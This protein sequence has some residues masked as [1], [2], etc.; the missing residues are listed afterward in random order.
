LRI[1]APIFYLKTVIMQTILAHSIPLKLVIQDLAKGFGVS[2]HQ[3]CNEYSLTLPSTYG[4]G[5]ITG[6]D[7]NDG[8]GLI[9]YDCTFYEAIQIKF[10]V[11]EIHPL[12]FL[13]CESGTISHQFENQTSW[14]VMEILDNMIVASDEKNGHVLRFEAG[15]KTVVNSLEVNRAEFVSNKDCIL[16]TLG[17]KS[18]ELF[19]DTTASKSFYHHSNYSVKMADL[20]IEF[21]EFQEEEFLR[22]LFLESIASEILIYQILQYNDDIALPENKTVLRKSEIKLI[23][24]AAA[25]IDNNILNFQSVQHLANQVGIN[26]NKL[27]NGFKEIYRKTVN[28]YVQDSR[29]DLANNLL[30]NTDSS[31]SEIVYKIGLSSKSYFS[32]IYK[33][34]YGCSPS[35]IR[36]KN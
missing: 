27:Q 5:S 34:K 12:K 24:E 15:V 21:H 30:K 7:L 17:E 18:Q 33:N 13:F 1:I 32:K 10:S 22:N 4:E 35:E 9:F 14:H 20:F 11:N 2:F 6:I 26:I 23:Q 16:K 25:L 19:R 3:N 8:L 36:K 31:I 28:M 29:L